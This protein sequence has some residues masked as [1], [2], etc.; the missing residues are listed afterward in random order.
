VIASPLRPRDQRQEPGIAARGQ[1][2]HPRNA[3]RRFTFVRHH[4]ASRASFRHALTGAGRQAGRDQ[5]PSSHPVNSGPRPCLRCWIPPNGLQVRTHTSDLNIRARHTSASASGLGSAASTAIHF[6]ASPK[7]TPLTRSGAVHRPLEV[8]RRCERIGRDADLA[9]S[10]AP[11]PATSEPCFARA[12]GTARRPFNGA[13]A[14]RY[15]WA[16]LRVASLEQRDGSG[17]GEHGVE[18]QGGEGVCVG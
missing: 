1:L 8:A 10:R 16:V 11:D 6:T 4:D 7:V 14:A 17:G 3:L 18:D 2:A 5:P 13:S 12:T 15:R 9:M